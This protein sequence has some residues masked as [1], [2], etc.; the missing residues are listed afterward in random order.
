ME[1]LVQIQGLKKHFPPKK[2]SSKPLRAVDG[3]NLTVDEG[4]TLGLVGE[5][6]C[7]KT[8]LGRT[9]LRLLAP[10]EGEISFKGKSIDH[11]DRK[12]LT[13]KMSVVFQDPTASLNPRMTVSDH[14]RRPLE[15]HGIAK[16]EEMIR[17]IVEFLNSMG[18]KSE[19]MV[20]YPHEMSGGQKQRVCIA[21]ALC[22]EPSFIVL[23]EPTSALDVS[24][25]SKILKLLERAKREYTV[26][27]L[28][29]SH[30][31][32][33]VRAISNRI[34]VM[35]LGRIV[36]IGN[37]DEV[38]QN[39]LHPYTKALFASVPQPDPDKKVKNLLKGEVPS[40]V[41]LPEGCSFAPRC[42]EKVGRICDEEKPPVKT[43]NG[44]EI[45]CH[46]V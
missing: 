19:H 45:A 38:F 8:T 41:N 31:I 14:L 23:D 9:I 25:Q 3:V 32:N 33:L 4:E 44:R 37:T 35:Y 22:V 40:P 30:D 17:R 5:S 27:Y 21:R 7:G 15:I 11:F 34:G 43:H 20:R 13:K 26:S 18:L 2:G 46:R 29:I 12:E 1:P 24:V 6:G 10:T 39:P 42:K 36:E 16:G 28:F